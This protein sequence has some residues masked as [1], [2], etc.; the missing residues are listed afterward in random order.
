MRRCRRASASPTQVRLNAALWHW[1][2]VAA[3]KKALGSSCFQAIHISRCVSASTVLWSLTP[4]SLPKRRSLRTSHPTR[5]SRSHGRAKLRRRRL[6]DP[7][8]CFAWLCSC[9]QADSAFNDPMELLQQRVGQSGWLWATWCTCRA[10]TTRARQR[11]DQSR[12]SSRSATE[13]GEDTG[14][15]DALPPLLP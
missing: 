12:R 10:D 2:R 1:A 11:Q 8:Q 9:V 7:R 4:L 6:R 13:A 5:L 3:A 15:D 14:G